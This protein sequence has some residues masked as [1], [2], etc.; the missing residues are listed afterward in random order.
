MPFR[1]TTGTPS[2][3]TVL[4]SGTL[5][6]HG[7]ITNWTV[8]GATTLTFGQ[9]GFLSII[10][11]TG[12]SATG[13]Q[14]PSIHGRGAYLSYTA[15]KTVT[16]PGSVWVERISVFGINW[17]A[18]HNAFNPAIATLGYSM[19]VDLNAVIPNGVT[20]TQVLINAWW[21]STGHTPTGF[22]INVDRR[23][24]SG[25]TTIGT[26]TPSQIGSWVAPTISLSESVTSGRSYII[27][28]QWSAIGDTADAAKAGVGDVSI[29]Y[30]MPD[31]KQTL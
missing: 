27:S 18:S 16:F 28:A 2:D 24:G 25:F 10:P 1:R 22:A 5:E 21:S 9:T 23:T 14:L 30:T 15:T 31:P 13:T 11:F 17:D 4:A 8:N 19:V 26:V 29:T 20:I 12:A 7:A 3:A 6:N